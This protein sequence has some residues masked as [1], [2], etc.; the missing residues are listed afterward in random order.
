MKHYT[1]LILFVLTLWT[2]TALEVSGAQSGT[3]T[4]DNNPYQIVGDITVP[5]NSVLTIQPGVI[6]QAMGNF[7]INTEGSIQAVGTET[8]SI[9]FMNAQTPPTA[10]WKGLRLDSQAT[11]SNFKYC[12]VEYATDGIS[13]VDA[14]VEISYCRFNRN[15]CG[16]KLYGIGNLDPAVMN[17]HHNLVEYSINNG[18]LIPQN[19]N[20]W[21]HHNEVRFNGTG[22][23]YYGAIQ[24]SN[25]SANGQ[26]NPIIEH[27]NVHHNFKQGIT[28]WDVTGGSA[29]NPIIRFNHIEAN[30]T[31]IYLLYASGIVHDNLI[32][33]NFIAG[34]MNSGAGMMIGGAT[35]VP[36]IARNTLTGNYTGFYI[37]ANA[38]PVLGDLSENHA[39]AFGENIIRDNIDATNVLNSV[40]C[41]AYPLNTNTIKAENN[42]WGAYT[43]A[44]IAIGIRDQNDNPA[45]PT[46]DFEPWFAE[47]TPLTISGSYSWNMDDYAVLAP[48][49]LQVLLVAAD[50]RE[51]LETHVL[52]SNPFSF[53]TEVTEPFFALISAVD[54]TREIWAA[55]GGL[56]NCTTFDPA[57]A[58]DIA[59]GVIHIAA[60]QHYDME[61]K[62]E[63]ELIEGYEMWP[64]Y[65]SFLIFPYDRVD[66]FYDE[67]DSR[68]IYKHE[69][70]DGQEWHT[71]NLG[72]HQHYAKIANIEYADQWAQ[73]CVENGQITQNM[74]MCLIDDNGRK[75]IKTS[76]VS[77]DILK[78]QRFTDLNSDLIYLYDGQGFSDRYLEVLQEDDNTWIKYHK[79][80]LTHPHEL[81]LRVGH[82]YPEQAF[83]M[84]FW[85]QAP[86]H[87]ATA[88]NAYRLYMQ[89]TGHEAQLIATVT[90]AYGPVHYE[91]FLTG[92]GPV[93]FWVVATDGTIESAPSNVI[94]FEFPISN[95]DLVQTPQLNI[96]PNPV[97]LGQ[98]NTLKIETK[99]LLE[100][101]L[102]IYNI[103]GQQI[104]SQKQATKDFEWP[105]Q[106]RTGQTVGSGIY[107]LRL[108][109]SNQA[110]INRK[111]MV[112]K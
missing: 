5:A 62:G 38:M 91:D 79:P 12:Y 77:D 96:Y 28:A 34:D 68:F 21:I 42:D 105:G 26:N 40:V 9:F 111:I 31:G 48:G 65:Y 85:W 54:E 17:V 67:G 102:K 81:S 23:Q 71:V 41:D 72:L 63:T 97:R 90:F 35:S 64:V 7:Q 6:V 87:E 20:A 37:T 88:Y 104:F 69:Y 61:T 109:S 4:P 49:E 60:W 30:L 50:S 93:E 15:K 74:V 73:T 24:L 94:N 1:L 107:M 18:I 39:W 45:L 92:S 80:N 53:E 8:D 103:R 36:H 84:H 101:C 43:A 83:A 52:Q 44:E 32:I 22:T 58:A 86:A 16:L 108:E 70:N 27:N 19:S 99:G 112:I 76:S 75:L 3:W 10:T 13:A 47:Q 14:P 98:G 78:S 59:V 57:D 11:L 95:E 33:N 46:V 29:I 51:I 82:Q 89:H 106:D 56:Q 110:P 2:L 25:Q 66:Y 55:A 100:P